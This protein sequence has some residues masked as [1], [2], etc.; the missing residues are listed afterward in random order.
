VEYIE[1][2]DTKTII[3]DLR[4]RTKGAMLLAVLESD[5][6]LNDNT[7]WYLF[8]T[9]KGNYFRQSDR[10]SPTGDL[11]DSN[12]YKCSLGHAVHIYELESTEQIVAWEDA[13]PH[14]I[15]DA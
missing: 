15:E 9:A 4:Y 13:F 6:S 8:R 12:I 10:R 7:Y 3:G 2:A 1:P 11:I 5:T 14:G